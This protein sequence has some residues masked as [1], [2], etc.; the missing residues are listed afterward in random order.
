MTP[1]EKKGYEVG[2]VFEVIEGS[3]PYSGYNTRDSVF[4][5]GAIIVLTEDDGTSKPEFTLLK[6]YSW[7]KSKTQYP[8]LHKVKRIYP[9]EEREKP[10]TIT[11]MGKEYVK[12]DIENALADVLPVK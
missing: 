1:C 6:G 3:A 10:E 7:N 11:L 2:Q 12:S 8:S 5:H 9:P 4:S